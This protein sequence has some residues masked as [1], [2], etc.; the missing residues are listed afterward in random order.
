LHV[1]L[2]WSYHVENL[3][4]TV[5]L[6][7]TS[8]TY[9][10]SSAE[11]VFPEPQLMDTTCPRGRCRH[12][13]YS[14]KGDNR[15]QGNM[16]RSQDLKISSLTPI[17]WRLRGKGGPNATPLMSANPTHSSTP[18]APQWRPSPTSISKRVSE[19]DA[20]GGVHIHRFILQGT[21]RVRDP[22]SARGP[23]RRSGG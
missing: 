11:P 2:G 4:F 22:T 8:R 5:K 20:S 10:D 1:F 19:V 6:S 3:T 14:A 7:S 18:V 9:A 23:G 13:F 16:A 17:S 21:R 12:S 15:A